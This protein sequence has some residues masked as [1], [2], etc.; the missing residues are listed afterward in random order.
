MTLNSASSKAVRTN[1]SSETLA[2]MESEVIELPLLLPRW[3]VQALESAAQRRGIT[4][5]QMLR[6]LIGEL[7][8]STPPCPNS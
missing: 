3:Q 4:T 6:R 2:F 8:D 7:F 1:E 5:A